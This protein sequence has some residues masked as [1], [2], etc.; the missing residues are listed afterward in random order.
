MTSCRAHTNDH[1]TYYKAFERTSRTATGFGYPPRSALRRRSM[2]L[3]AIDAG[4]R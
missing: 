3:G 1:T 2:P 4:D